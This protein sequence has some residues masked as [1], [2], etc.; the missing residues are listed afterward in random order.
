MSTELP[1]SVG[2]IGLGN[3]GRPMAA[4]LARAG[5]QL[6][7]G[8][9]HTARQESFAAEFD[10]RAADDPEAFADVQTLVTMLP[11]GQVV[12]EVLLDAGIAAALPRGAV[13]IDTSSSEPSGTIELGSALA[14]LGLSLVDAPV[15]G[16]MAKA[17]DGTLAIMLGADDEA[18]AERAI[19]VL[20][21]MSTRIFRTGALGTGHAM[22]ALNNFVLAA[23]F[24]AA[25]EALVVGG[26]FGLDPAVI[27]EVLNASSGRNVSTET[28]LIEEVL[29]RRFAANF[30]LG[31]FTKDLGIAVDLANELDIDAPLCALVHERLVQAG[32]ELGWETDYSAV[33]AL[34][35]QRAG[36]ELPRDD[37]RTGATGGNSSSL[38]GSL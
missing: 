18:A 20:K 21:A 26:K 37:L 4:N 38:G 2:F 24:E 33:V 30:T 6:V 3:M 14:D 17:I 10:V 7:V 12:R 16:G 31:L 9:A 15:S 35:E 22:K 19:P 11:T 25:A 23:G 32:E 5:A 27:V 13:A 1:R 28:T 8:D 34:W 29:T 36:I